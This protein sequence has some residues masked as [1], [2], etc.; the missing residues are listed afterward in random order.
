[1]H[2]VAE[3]KPTL[4]ESVAAI[5]C[6]APPNPGN[7]AVGRLS[8]ELHAQAGAVVTEKE[9]LCLCTGHGVARSSFPER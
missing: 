5:S 6:D 9:E 1:M 7:G 2:G 8:G 3:W 4:N